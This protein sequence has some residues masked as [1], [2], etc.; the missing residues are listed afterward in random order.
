MLQYG[1]LCTSVARTSLILIQCTSNYTHAYAVTG[2]LFAHLHYIHIDQTSLQSTFS[3][4][5][6]FSLGLTAMLASH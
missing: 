3:T 4:G 2:R 1:L 5:F 6:F